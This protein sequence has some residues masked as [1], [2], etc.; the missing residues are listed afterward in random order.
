MN[1]PQSTLEQLGV[2]FRDIVRDAVRTEL[3]AAPSPSP[4]P[5]ADRLGGIKL[6]SEVTGMAEQ[7][8]YNLASRREVPFA[9]RGGKLIFSESELRQW[10]MENRRPMQREIANNANQ[11]IASP[12]RKGGKQR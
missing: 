12:R 4:S 3:Q 9:K 8:G 11:F 6:F 7:T 1:K 10:M 5:P 2:I